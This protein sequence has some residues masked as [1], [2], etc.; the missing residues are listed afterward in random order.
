MEGGGGE[1]GGLFIGQISIAYYC[2][3]PMWK[4]KQTFISSPQPL[5]ATLSGT[6]KSSGSCPPSATA[7]WTTRTPLQSPAFRERVCMRVCE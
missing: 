2:V 7:L 4:K 5:G 6:G 3:I 1:G